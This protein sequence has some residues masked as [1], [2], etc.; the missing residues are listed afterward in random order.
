MAHYILMRP[1]STKNK[2]ERESESFAEHTNDSNL[3][4]CLS[5]PVRGSGLRLWRCRA[6]NET[7]DSTRYSKCLYQH[8]DTFQKKMHCTSIHWV[9]KMF[10]QF[11]KV[12]QLPS[13]IEPFQKV[14]QYK[15]MKSLSAYDACSSSFHSSS[16]SYSSGLFNRP[17]EVEPNDRSIH[18]P[19]LATKAGCQ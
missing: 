11:L 10:P 9:E 15:W 16:T 4:V 5:W 12:E 3:A 6:I 17:S 7:A 18:D 13:W 14:E 19:Q 1:L 8:D 2:I